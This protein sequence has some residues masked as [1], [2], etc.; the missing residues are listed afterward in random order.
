MT[1]PVYHL[2]LAADWAAARQA[3]EYRISTLGRTLDQQGYIHASF[4]HQVAGVFEAFYRAVT[5]PLVLLHL[6]VAALPVVLEPAVPGSAAGT[7]GAE[8]FPHVYGPLPVSAVL[9]VH[10]VPDPE[11]GTVTPVR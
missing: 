8:L 10:P 6:D 9:A 2:A 5:E 11:T 3:G 4:A 1:E 7:P